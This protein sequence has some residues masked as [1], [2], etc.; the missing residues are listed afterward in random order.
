MHLKRAMTSCVPAEVV[1]HES[2]DSMSILQCNNIR[3]QCEAAEYEP[4]GKNNPKYY[5]LC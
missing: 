4:L 3:A 1:L 2:E 5:Q